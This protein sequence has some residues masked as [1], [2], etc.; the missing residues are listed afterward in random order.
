MNGAVLK[1][2][3]TKKISDVNK[4]EQTLTF[5]YYD[6]FACRW[7]ISKEPYKESLIKPENFAQIVFTPGQ[8]ESR[9]VYRWIPFVVNR[10]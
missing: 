8:P 7:I 9:F 4:K 2:K 10:L 1:R 3:N 5:Y 6:N